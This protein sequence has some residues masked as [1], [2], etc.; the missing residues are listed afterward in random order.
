MKNPLIALILLLAL[1]AGL[2]LYDLGAK[3]FWSDE[4]MIWWIAQGA[5]EYDAPASYAWTLGWGNRLVGWNE[6]A[7][8][9]PS[10]VYGILF[11]ISIYV[12]VSAFF[13]LRAGWI[14]GLIAAVSAFLVPISQELRV[15]SLLGLLILWAL[16]IFLK[17]SQEEKIRAGWWAA[18][19]AVSLAG[20]WAHCFFIF[21]LGFFG[22]ILTWRRGWKI[23]GTYW[24]ITGAA[25]LVSLP[26]LLNTLSLAGS[27]PH[28][29]AADLA[30]LAMNARRLGFSYFSFFFGDY[31]VNLPPSIREYLP[32]HPGRLMIAAVMTISTGAIFFIILKTLSRITRGGSFQA[33][34]LRVMICMAAAFSLLFLIVDVSSPAHL[35]FVYI[36]LLILL[37]ASWERTQSRIKWVVAALFL[38]L[39]AVS[40]GDYY[41]SPTFACER[42]DWRGAGE[43]LKRDL[44]AD[45]AVLFFRSRD[46]YHTL[47][48]Y[49]PDLTHDVYYIP[50]HNPKAAKD[51]ALIAWWTDTSPDQKVQSLLGKHPRVWLMESDPPGGKRIR[52]T[53]YS[54][55]RWDFGENLGVR[56]IIGE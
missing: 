55:R 31:L 40:L 48:F 9:L 37:A 5:V 13:N 39:T 49:L 10:V 19:L 26:Q 4:G 54:G 23:G 24:A 35:I 56:L 38:V 15:Y 34:V 36:P 44:K 29:G 3:S 16:G 42:A 47:R 33:Y 12:I 22:L 2:R 43:L 14:A 27:R 11:V 20:Q 8:R 51:A 18:L 30:H 17:L 45:D 25:V 46:A 6:F 32:T 21:V 41:R 50:R 52:L 7:G 53:E 28:T 1:A